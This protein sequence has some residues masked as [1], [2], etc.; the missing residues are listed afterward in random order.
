MDAS[1]TGGDVFFITAVKRASKDYDEALDVY[2]AREC[3]DASLCFPLVPEVPQACSTGDACKA[4]PTP[5]PSIFGSAPSATFSGAGNVVTPTLVHGSVKTKTVSRAKLL[6]K[7]LQKCR[8][9]ARAK[10]RLCERTARKRYVLAAQEVRQDKEGGSV[11]CAR[12][13][14]FAS[15]R[16]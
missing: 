3:T 8:K 2:D 5:Q 14:A 1:T 9:R 6:R 16:L 7:A 4:A 12:S 11:I 15:L 10:R 13:R